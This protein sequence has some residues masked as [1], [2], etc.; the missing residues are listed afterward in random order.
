MAAALILWA[1][2]A[3]VRAEDTDTEGKVITSLTASTTAA[4]DVELSWTAPN[5]TPTDY[6]VNYAKADTSYPASNKQKGNLFPAESH[7][8]LTNLKP[9]E[10][11][12]IR[13]RARYRP[14]GKAGAW[15]S[16]LTVTATSKTVYG[17]VATSETPATMTLDWDDP[18]AAPSDYRVNYAKV[19]AEYPRGTD[20]TAN[21]YPTVSELTIDGLEEGAEYKIRVRARYQPDGRRGPW[22]DEVIVTV[23]Q[24][25]MRISMYGGTMCS[26]AHPTGGCPARNPVTVWTQVWLSEEPPETA[27]YIIRIELKDNE[28]NDANQCEG[29]D[30]GTDVEVASES[31]D[32][33][34]GIVH[35]HT[36]TSDSGCTSGDYKIVISVLLKDSTVSQIMTTDMPLR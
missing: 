36:Y 35:Y 25:Q 34:P 13:V 26:P 17:L 5:L 29:P 9:G 6:R 3:G 14:N 21:N 32:I 30:M 28:G 8:T 23:T 10:E 27:V 20:S 19:G 31:S 22:S 11:Y 2:A 18:T 24:A 15:S 33:A 12:K 4:G 7:A 1:P 16:E